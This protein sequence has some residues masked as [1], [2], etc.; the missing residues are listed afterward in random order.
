MDEQHRSYNVPEQASQTRWTVIQCRFLRPYAVIRNVGWLTQMSD[1]SH[2][3]KKSFHS[4]KLSFFGLL[5]VYCIQNL[6]SQNQIV[7]TVYM[8]LTISTIKNTI[9][10]LIT[11][12]SYV[13]I[14]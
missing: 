10:F 8:D 1:K 6:V 3:Y 9:D 11:T 7:L 13:D 14:M 2:F 5:N 4:L 12:N